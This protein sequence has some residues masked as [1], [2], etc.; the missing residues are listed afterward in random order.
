MSLS[1]DE[2]TGKICSCKPE[3]DSM[4]VMKIV[5]KH[6]RC[7]SAPISVFNDVQEEHVYLPAAALRLAAERTQTSPA[8]VA[9]DRRPIPQVVKHP[10]CIHILLDEKHLP[11]GNRQ[12]KAEIYGNQVI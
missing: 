2:V 5:D 9:K 3:V 4:D 12:R 10:H 8:Y 11:D 1:T 7:R 6:R